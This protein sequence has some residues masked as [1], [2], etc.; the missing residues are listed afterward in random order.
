MTDHNQNTAL[1]LHARKKQ[2]RRGLDRLA[3]MRRDLENKHSAPE[4]FQQ[5]MAMGISDL[6]SIL[7]RGMPP[8]SSS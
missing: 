2:I 6:E 4:V 7:S 3:L 1:E 5:N 8:V